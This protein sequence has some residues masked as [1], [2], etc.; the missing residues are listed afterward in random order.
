MKG[1]N[2][3]LNS[4]NLETGDFLRLFLLRKSLYLLLNPKR[5]AAADNPAIIP[6]NGTGVAGCFVGIGCAEG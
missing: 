5:T 4:F 2:S 6:A 1:L 3:Y